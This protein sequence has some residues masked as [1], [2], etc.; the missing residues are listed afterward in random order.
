M[1]RLQREDIPTRSSPAAP[2][3]ILRLRSRIVFAL[4]LGAVKRRADG[5]QWGRVDE[6]E[7]ATVVVVVR[8]RVRLRSQA[9]SGTRPDADAAAGWNEGAAGERGRRRADGRTDGRTVGRAGTV[10]KRETAES[11]SQSGGWTVGAA[12]ERR[13][14]RCIHTQKESDRVRWNRTKG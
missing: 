3:L 10:L 12:R 13:G 6:A 14:R 9:Q 1:L 5:M 2:S 8:Q 11:V 7:A 4:N